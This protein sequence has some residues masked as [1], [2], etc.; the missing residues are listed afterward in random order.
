M[1]GGCQDNGCFRA[2]SG[3]ARLNVAEK[4]ALSGIHWAANNSCTEAGT[5]QWFPHES[6]IHKPQYPISVWL[7]MANQPALPD[8]ENTGKTR[9]AIDFVG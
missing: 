8:H 6:S 2:I 4:T 3:M 1:P 9:M 5:P 7:I